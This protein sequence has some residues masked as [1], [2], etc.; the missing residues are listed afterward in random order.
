[1]Q[2]FPDLSS[3]RHR[4]LLNGGLAAILLTG[5]IF[6]G[7]GCS[8][9]GENAS[10]SEEQLPVVSST[11]GSVSTAAVEPAEQTI[12]A[13]RMHEPVSETEQSDRVS[14]SD[15]MI[16]VYIPSGG[17]TMGSSDADA[18]AAFERC[19]EVFGEQCTWERYA[20]ETPLHTVTLDE[21]WID[22]TEVTNAMYARFLNEMGNCTSES[23]RCK[24]VWYAA[25]QED[26]RL[27]LV[28]GIWEPQSGY[29]EHPV[30]SVTWH[31]AS[32]YCE[33][34]GRR[35]PSEAEW[36]RAA[37]GT[38]L[39]PYPWGE[40]LP[41]GNTANFCD[42]NCSQDSM[43]PAIDDGYAGTAPVGSY[44]EG[45]SPFGVLDL[46]GNV[47]EW[48]ADW[49]DA[50]YYQKSPEDNPEG[51]RSWGFK[52]IRGGSFLSIDMIL[53]AATRA[54]EN[55]NSAYGSLGFRCASSE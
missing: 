37:R 2:L 12:P 35:L 18:L 8:R 55:I 34:A 48:T 25:G 39:E 44:P 24:V 38:S 5:W 23:L 1:M 14:G 50:G 53:R 49:Y 31:G 3:P 51:P 10:T 46:S 41:D 4:L 28:E 21:F 33:W 47:W 17:F 19:K 16:L 29:E 15:G 32:A 20:D 13:S 7:S 9:T 52:V 36:E 11:A 40:E 42:R 54:D 26:A 27:A 43:D 45:Q 30:T 22:Q 6:L